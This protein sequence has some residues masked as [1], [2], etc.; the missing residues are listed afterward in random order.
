MRKKLNP[1]R[2]VNSLLNHLRP[3]S[4]GNHVADERSAPPGQYGNVIHQY[5]LLLK[6]TLDFIPPYF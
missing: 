2:T 5:A 1:S 4:P 6:F 3:P